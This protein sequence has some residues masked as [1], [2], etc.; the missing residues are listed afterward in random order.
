[1]A[2]VVD[3][4]EVGV[5][6]VP[7]KFRASKTA[8]RCGRVSTRGRGNVGRRI[9]KLAEEEAVRFL[10]TNEATGLTEEEAAARRLKVYGPN[11]VDHHPQPLSF[12]YLAP[13][14][15][16]IIISLL[17]GSLNACC[18][19]KRL[20]NHAKAPLEAI[21][22]A[23]RVKVLRDGIW[24]DENVTNLLPGDIIIY[25]KCGDIVPAN[26][27]VLN[28]VRIDTKIIR[29]ERCVDSVKG[30][31]IY[32]GWAVFCGEG[33]AVVTAT[34]NG[35]PRSTLKLYPK[36]FSSP[37]QLRK[38]V[39]A[40]GS[41]CFCLILVG[42]IAE[43]SCQILF[44]AKRGRAADWPLC[45][46]NW[47]NTNGHACCAPP[48]IDKLLLSNDDILFN[49]TGT[50]TCNKPCFDK[51]KV[52][53]YADGIDKDHAILL[54]ARASKAHNEL[55]KEP[56]D[57]AILGLIDDP[58]QVRVGI[59]VIEHH[60]RFFVAMIL[61]YMTTYIDGNGSKCS[62]LKVDSALVEEDPR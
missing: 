40:A 44:P 28:L 30:S 50:L 46:A 25:L 17:G 7:E 51:D 8:A 52:E 35:I 31:H 23:P 26:A 59:E 55:Y 10:G 49:T 4:R 21:A 22:F 48:G 18:V 33:T 1:M 34:V 42:I 15:L 58:E 61:M 14:E 19:A 53:V 60:S 57:A 56:I 37:G 27:R 29:D 32:Y 16:A 5:V 62:V 12:P 6:V 11:I 39:M 2:K 43:A 20:A 45:A 13:Y 47:C 24:K 36:R 54:A 38:G 9:D 3:V 41:C